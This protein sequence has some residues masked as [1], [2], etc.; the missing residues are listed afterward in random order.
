MS[1]FKQL[2]PRK[3]LAVNY[4][5]GIGYYALHISWMVLIFSVYL[6]AMQY[7]VSGGSVLDY[8]PP[9]TSS[10]PSGSGGLHVSGFVSW[11]VTLIAGVAALLFV[12]VLPYFIG[13]LSRHLPIVI[14]EQTNW[15]IT[16]TTVLYVK[17]AMVG[18]VFVFAIAALYRPYAD[19]TQNVPFFIVSGSC[20]V[21]MISFWLQHI[22]AALWKVPQR[23]I[24]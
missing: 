18:C 3:Q 24:F 11:T 20:L 14:L 17:Q 2:H 22:I 5:G 21:A 1:I 23:S 9:H 12:V 16:S 4:I 6:F 15:R 19:P 10:P 8:T 7:V 13:Q